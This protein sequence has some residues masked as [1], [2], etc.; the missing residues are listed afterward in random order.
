M[1]SVIF[2]IVFLFLSFSLIS[3]EIIKGKA[4][5]VNSDYIKIENQII[6]L[7]GI[8]AMERP[9]VCY[10]ENKI[11]PCYDITVR[12]LESL[13]DLGETECQIIKKSR[14][15]R[16]FGTCEVVGIE[17]NQELVEKGWALARVKQRKD[18]L[19]FQKIAEEKKLGIWQSQFIEPWLWRKRFNV[20]NDP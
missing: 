19:K 5:V 16:V 14:M 20:P 11:W 7:Y 17:I 8:E 12:F 9:Q 6:I 4:T 15:N 2:L 1:K 13:V 3:E 10:I 18:Y